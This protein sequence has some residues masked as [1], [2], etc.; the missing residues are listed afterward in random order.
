MC[1]DWQLQVLIDDST[2]LQEAYPGGNAEHIAHQQAIV[3]ENWEILQEKAAQRKSDLQATM[4]LYWFL[5]AVCSVDCNRNLRIS[6][7]LLKSYHKSY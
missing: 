5:S 2:R 7:A 6:D 1:L 3:V 4:D